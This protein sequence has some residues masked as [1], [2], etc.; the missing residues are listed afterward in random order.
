MSLARSLAV[1]H[2]N[3]PKISPQTSYYTAFLT[4]L[5]LIYPLP[6]RSYCLISLLII[7]PS[8]RKQQKRPR[9]STNEEASQQVSSNP[10]SNLPPPTPSTPRI[11]LR[12]P[13]AGGVAPGSALKLNPPKP[14]Q[15][16]APTR[17]ASRQAL[18]SASSMAPP[19]KLPKP[20]KPPASDVSTSIAAVATRPGL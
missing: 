20:T 14:P 3:G 4:L 18:N 1:D 16:P 19:T 9:A 17:P 15:P 12:P 8:N 5:S 6:P 11:R 2:T 13:H 7:M 10:L